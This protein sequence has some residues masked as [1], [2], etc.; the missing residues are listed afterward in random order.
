MFSNS[1]LVYITYDCW[2]V[3]IHG[4][5][6]IKQRIFLYYMA[7]TNREGHMDLKT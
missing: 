4:Y 6:R 1:F 3:Y 7:I 5:G 2:I